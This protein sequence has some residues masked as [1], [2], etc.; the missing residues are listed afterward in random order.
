MSTNI[1]AFLLLNKFREGVTTEVLLK[2]LEILQAEL[3]GRN[4]DL[5]INSDMKEVIK[6][7]VRLITFSE[8]LIC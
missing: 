3:Q 6:H 5:S 1:I 2:E 4:H 8:I 7:G